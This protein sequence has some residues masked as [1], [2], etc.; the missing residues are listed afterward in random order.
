MR[1]IQVILLQNLEGN[2]KHNAN[3]QWRKSQSLLVYSVTT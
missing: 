3:F 1:I 2:Y